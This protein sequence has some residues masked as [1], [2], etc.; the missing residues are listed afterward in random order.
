M[1]NPLIIAISA[2]AVLTGAVGGAGPEKKQPTP[3]IKPDLI[4]AL[5]KYDYNLFIVSLWARERGAEPRAAASH[6]QALGGSL[7]W[8][9]FHFRR[10][11]TLKT[12]QLT[13]QTEPILFLKIA[14]RDKPPTKEEGVTSVIIGLEP[15]ETEIAQ[16]ITR[17]VKIEPDPQYQ[18]PVFYCLNDYNQCISRETRWR[19]MPLIVLCMAQNVIPLTP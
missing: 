9:R 18:S 7:D 2:A 3:Y 15:V 8:Y 16:A 13:Q 19:C 10:E 12:G 11:L 14:P 1:G 4:T 17:T 6:Y 5:N